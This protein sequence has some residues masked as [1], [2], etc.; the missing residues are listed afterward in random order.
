MRLHH[1]LSHDQQ[2]ADFTFSPVRT[3]HVDIDALSLSRR[4]TIPPGTVEPLN[5][6]QNKTQ[7][8]NVCTIQEGKLGYYFKQAIYLDSVNVQTVPQKRRA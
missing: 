6:H 2:F 5:L 7:T 1:F 8:V 4:H 3:A